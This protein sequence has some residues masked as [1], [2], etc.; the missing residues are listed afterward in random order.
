MFRIYNLLKAK[1]SLAVFCPDMVDF[2]IT[3]VV[4]NR[5]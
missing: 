3:T 5:Y 1:L 2:L 4:Y